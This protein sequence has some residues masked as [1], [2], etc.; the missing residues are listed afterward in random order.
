MKPF[1]SGAASILITLAASA[2]LAIPATS[3]RDTTALAKATKD[4]AA[5]TQVMEVSGVCRHCRVHG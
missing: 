1:L 2:S 5:E 4:F 3:A